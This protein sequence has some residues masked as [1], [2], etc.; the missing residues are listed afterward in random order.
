MP[1]NPSQA[2]YGDIQ[3]RDTALV[4]IV[5]IGSIYISTNSMT[6]D[7]QPVLPL[8]TSN[9]S[10]KE[11]I[12]ISTRRY[13]ISN[14]SI[15]INNYPYEGQRFSERVEGSLINDPVEVYWISPSTTTLEGEDDGAF[16][17]YQGKVRKY[18]HDD[19]NCKITAEDKSQAT[20]H[21]DLPTAE[22]GTG[23]DVPDKYK[24][25]KIPL[26][27]GHVD[28]SPVVISNAEEG[29]EQAIVKKLSIDSDSS[30]NTASDKIIE[31]G[32]GGISFT[33]S[34]LYV[35]EDGYLSLNEYL[36]QDSS[37]E[38]NYI[39]TNN[40][41]DFLGSSELAQGVL[42]TWQVAEVG[43]IT[44]VYNANTNGENGF[45]DFYSGVLQQDGGTGWISGGAG[46]W[47]NIIDRSGSSFI[48]IYGN[49][50]ISDNTTGMNN[51]PYG[52][53][54][55]DIKLNTSFDEISTYLIMKVEKGG[56]NEV[57]WRYGSPSFITEGWQFWVNEDYAA[58]ESSPQSD[59]IANYDT[60]DLFGFPMLTHSIGNGTATT[61]ETYQIGVPINFTSSLQ[62]SPELGDTPIVDYRFHEFH[63]WQDI[64][65]D[66]LFNRNFYANVNGRAISALDLQF[67][68]G[69]LNND[70]WIDAADVELYEDCDLAD[71]CFDLYGEQANVT[72][73]SS[74]SSLDIV[75]MAQAL[76]END[77]E[78][79]FAGHFG[80]TTAS[81]VG[82]PTA[83]VAIKHIL[84]NELGQTG[85]NAAGTY[86]WQYA[87]CQNTK[88]NSKKLIENIAS[89][90]P[91]IPYYNNRG[92][93]HF[94]EIPKGGGTVIEGNTI[95]EAD[96]ID[97]SFSRSS[98][99]D[100]KSRI[101]FKYNWDYAR[102][103]FND[104]VEADISLLG[105]EDDD[106]TLKYKH[107]YYGLPDDDSES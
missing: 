81:V 49:Q 76:L 63:V 28:R 74:Y 66:N 102:G 84:E 70:G 103:E 100:V 101:I 106:T 31:F 3:G 73:E 19:S 23:D 95:K 6:Y 67:G 50:I 60:A 29:D 86:E 87:F 11:S 35:Y 42:S 68:I 97:F 62:G 2:F 4:P 44:P 8:L 80:W 10:L 25:K 54:K 65:V 34:P 12:D 51:T 33:E 41:I 27:I 90:S 59:A 36:N 14:I 52:A 26:V 83:P 56:T 72:G 40:I 93:F 9:P 99:N 64:K 13:K 46:N 57:G 1:L 78:P 98:I 92:D 58:F 38:Q 32:D 20:L 16:K 69:D 104:S 55:F 96:V 7:S 21:K 39:S 48:Q 15:T 17:I 75:A 88:I 24:G 18:D 47:D 61:V 79:L 53:F 105:Y 71:N 77:G 89:A 30:V 91:Y 85:I 82:S 43:K 45:L 22:L 37:S 94:T 5:K 107:S